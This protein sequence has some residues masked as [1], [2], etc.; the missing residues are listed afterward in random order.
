MFVVL[1][2]DCACLI[3]LAKTSEGFFSITFELWARTQTIKCSACLRVPRAQLQKACITWQTVFVLWQRFVGI[4][5]VCLW[6][7]FCMLWFDAHSLVFLFLSLCFNPDTSGLH[8]CSWLLESFS[9]STSFLPFADY[10]VTK[11]A[12]ARS[13]VGG[14]TW[15]QRCQPAE[16]GAIFAVTKCALLRH[17]CT[18]TA[19][20]L[21]MEFFSTTTLMK[22]KNVKMAL[23]LDEASQDVATTVVAAVYLSSNL[24]NRKW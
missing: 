8:F 18:F 23:W 13:R 5:F 7:S 1:R 15:W 22:H 20:A 3:K 11:D 17:W 6:V 2:P 24:V 4:L 12:N 10:L 9:L 21:T 19:A 14:T 16:H